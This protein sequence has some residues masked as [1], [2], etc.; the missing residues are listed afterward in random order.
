M[1]FTNIL[2]IQAKEKQAKCVQQEA[3]LRPV[4]PEKLIRCSHLH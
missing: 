3:N 4:Q 1:L 2:V